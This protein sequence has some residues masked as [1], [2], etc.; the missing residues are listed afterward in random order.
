MALQVLVGNSTVDLRYKTFTLATSSG[1]F[2]S[3]DHA[4]SNIVSTSDDART[5]AFF[6]VEVAPGGGAHLLYVADSPVA[7]VNGIAK[8]HTTYSSFEIAANVDPDTTLLPAVRLHGSAGASFTPTAEGVQTPGFPVVAVTL[9]EGV[10][11]TFTA[12][13][14]TEEIVYGP[15]TAHSLPFTAVDSEITITATVSDGTV[16]ASV[17]GFTLGSGPLVVAL[18]TLPANFVLT[19]GATNVAVNVASGSMAIPFILKAVDTG[20]YLT[21]SGASV[22]FDASESAAVHLTLTRTSKMTSNLGYALALTHSG[23]VLNGSQGVISSSIQTDVADPYTA[24]FLEQVSGSTYKV[25]GMT[26]DGIRR[27]VQVRSAPDYAFPMSVTESSTGGYFEL[28]RAKTG[29]FGTATTQGYLKQDKVETHTITGR[30]ADSGAVELHMAN[31]VRVWANDTSLDF[32]PSIT[33]SLFDMTQKMHGF[34]FRGETGASALTVDVASSDKTILSTEASSIRFKS[35]DSTMAVFDVNLQSDLAE[36][37]TGMADCNVKAQN[38]ALKGAQSTLAIEQDALRYTGKSLNFLD[39]TFVV[40]TDE[41]GHRDV[42]FDGEN[43]SLGTAVSNIVLDSIASEL[44]ATAA[45]M[46]FSSKVAVLDDVSLRPS[47]IAVPSYQL[48]VDPYGVFFKNGVM[49]QAEIGG[50]RINNTQ[51]AVMEAVDNAPAGHETAM[52]KYDEKSGYYNADGSLVSA[53]VRSAWEVAGGMLALGGNG[54]CDYLLGVEEDRLKVW[55]R[56]RSTSPPT[57]TVVSQFAPFL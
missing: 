11:A 24:M 16:T 41:I 22:F 29:K 23:S 43:V 19:D 40:T 13:D 51:I 50:L 48:I 20:D 37:N 39:G 8:L 15:V 26:P 1:N 35:D 49:Q 33:D 17:G 31:K 10:T 25:Y 4:S 44:S 45:K 5:A 21:S 28:V 34:R 6:T 30:S 27:L 54:I 2:L 18:P 38:I 14:A 36:L 47:Y 53:D 52:I 32:S 3:V 9:P 56:D 42:T 46:H 57:M 55:L 7:V 12:E